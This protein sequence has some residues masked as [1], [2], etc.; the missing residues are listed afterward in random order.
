LT[1][2]GGIP[3]ERLYGKTP[4]YFNLH[5]FGCVYYV[6]LAPRE[7]T[8]LT[9]QSID[10]VFLG[11]STEYKGY[12]CSNTVA[13]RM[14]MS[15]DV[16]FDESQPFYPCPTTDAFP[17]SLVDSLSFLFFSDAPPASLPISRSTLSSSVSSSE[18]H[19]VVLDYM[20][21]P[22]VT[23]FYSHR[24]A[25][26]SGAPASSDEFS[27]DVPSSSF[28]ED[29]PSSPVEPSSPTDSSLEQLVRRSHRLCRPHDCYSPSDFTVTALFELASYRDVILHLEWQHV[30]AKEI[31]ALE[32]TGTWDLVS[33]PSH[34]RL[35]TCKWIYKVKTRSDGSLECYKT[36]FV[37]CGF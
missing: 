17:A 15:Q 7:H 26:L 9:V 34:V 29:V 18:S 2:Q 22:P 11:Y 21:K 6:L 27:S 36:H 30:M 4:D 25:C 33:C 23:Q 31:A 12:H 5:L 19:P 3:F 32:R 13:R 14:R 20:M 35:F 10:C 37:A 8:K 16:A 28:I 24:G 1:L